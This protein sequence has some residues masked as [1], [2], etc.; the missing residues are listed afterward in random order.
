MPTLFEKSLAGARKGLE[1]EGYQCLNPD[2]SVPKR[3]TLLVVPPEPEMDPE[4]RYP[5]RAREL[6]YELRYFEEIDDLYG[7]IGTLSCGG[8]Y[9]AMAPYD[10]G[11]WIPGVVGVDEPRDC[12]Y[13]AGN[14]ATKGAA[15]AAW[16]AEYREEHD[17][18]ELAYWHAVFPELV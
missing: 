1:E 9:T 8:Y 4:Y 18:E 6:G 3:F 16:M 17:Q 14:A 5:R 12:E 11:E 13:S 7:E 10:N 2:S 15:E